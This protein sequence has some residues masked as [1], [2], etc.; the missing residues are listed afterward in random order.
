MYPGCNPMYPCLR[1]QETVAYRLARTR[2]VAKVAPPPHA[3]AIHG[4]WYARGAPWLW[5]LV[6]SPPRLLDPRSKYS[7][8]RPDPRMVCVVRLGHGHVRSR[9]SPGSGTAVPI[10]VL[11]CAPIG[12]PQM[13]SLL[14][15]RVCVHGHGICD[16]V[17]FC[18]PACCERVPACG[19]TPVLG[20]CHC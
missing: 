8:H 3:T 5:R 7:S 13:G 17:A 4:A 15:A 14:P 2:A 20:L 16:P 10:P 6:R 9:S 19:V 12:L 11:A 18:A 1:P